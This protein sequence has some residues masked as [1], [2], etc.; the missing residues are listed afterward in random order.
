MEPVGQDT[1]LIDETYDI[2]AG[3]ASTARN[4]CQELTVHLRER[5]APHRRIDVVLRAYDQG[6]AV[7][8][9]I[10]A[11]EALDTFTIVAERTQF[12]FAGDH[13]CWPTTY[14]NFL[15]SFEMEYPR[16]KLSALRPGALVGLPLT[17]QIDGGPA[18]ALAEARLMDYGGMYLE[19]LSAAISPPVLVSRIAPLHDG[20]Y[21]C[22]RAKA[23]HASPWRVIMLADSPVKLIESDLLYHLSDPCALAD[24]LWIKPGK[25][26]WDWWSGGA[27]PGRSFE[28]GHSTDLMK[29]YVD[30]AADLKLQY[31]L[32]DGGW[33]QPMH[34]PGADVTKSVP[35]LDLPG[36]VRYAAERGVDV[37]VWNYWSDLGDDF[38]RVFAYYRS[39]GIKGVKVDFFDRDD[40]WMVNHITQLVSKAAEYHLLLDLH[41]MYK[42]TGIERTWPNLMTH[43]GVLGGE[44]NKWS[45][46]V[47]PEHN[48]TLPFTRMLA[49]PMDYTP[50]AFV[51]ATKQQFEPRHRYPMV[52]GTRCHNLAMY[53]VYQSG[54]Q[55]VSDHPDAIRGQAGAD[56]LALV[57]AAWD[58]TIG[59]AGEIGQFVALARRRGRE[60]FIGAMCGDEPW[61]IE[62]PLEWLG[63]GQWNAAIWADGPKAGEQPTEVAT[64]R[65]VVKSA[66]G[67]ALELA[68]AGGAVVHLTPAS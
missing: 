52:M 37:M 12:V 26:T 50:G 63:K 66:D 48:V 43:E 9:V 28:G 6:A 33:Y 47:T 7:R 36:L 65:R 42:P 68:P 30:F 19:R 61:R 11:Q 14:P 29:H 22:V 49:G 20:T 10:P 8:Y 17:I 31:M 35:E 23:P 5:E 51:N 64:S 44:Y 58:Q 55:M 57:P 40:Q 32:V 18:A 59:L 45:A 13:T 53:V 15:S 3:K 34:R 1:R 24:T 46:R 27:A 54:L 41:G 56:F 25:V 2:V 4:H 16:Q 67:L 60:W 21:G 62:L 38:D 39:I